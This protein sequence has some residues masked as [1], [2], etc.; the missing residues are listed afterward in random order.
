M[1]S[2]WGLKK[3]ERN[4]EH[5]MNKRTEWTGGHLTYSLKPRYFCVCLFLSFPLH[6]DIFSS[7]LVKWIGRQD[8]HWTHTLH[9]HSMATVCLARETLEHAT[10]SFSLCVRMKYFPLSLSLIH[11][12]SI[13]L[14]AFHL[15][16]TVI[17]Q[18]REKKMLSL[19]RLPLSMWFKKMCKRVL[20]LH[21][22]CLSSSRREWVCERGEK[23]P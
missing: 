18:R 22:P 21:L 12:P 13:Y 23:V 14:F 20:H 4:K 5:R 2:T 19:G 10:N 16:L 9:A 6:N 11:L 1:Q 17:R 3:K 8:V 7:P 15:A